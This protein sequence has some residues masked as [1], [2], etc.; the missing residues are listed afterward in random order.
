MYAFP[1]HVIALEALEK[2]C[3]SKVI[4]LQTSL[5]RQAVIAGCRDMSGNCQRAAAW[6]VARIARLA[7]P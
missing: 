5:T 2:R 1:P 3:S 7:T 6:T 4:D